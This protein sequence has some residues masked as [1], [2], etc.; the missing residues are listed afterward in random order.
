[1]IQKNQPAM[2]NSDK[3]SEKPLSDPI[4]TFAVIT[5]GHVNPEDDKSASPWESNR[6]A[7][8][9]NR[10][11]VHKL[12]QLAPDFVI[13]LG[14]LI[15]P[16]PSQPS[17]PVAAKRFYEIYQPLES[18]I[19]FVPGNHDVGDKPS[20]WTP[21]EVVNRNFLS[22]FDRH[23]EKDF[24]SFEYHDSLFVLLNSQ[25]FNSGLKEEA[26]QQRWV[27][28]QLAQNSNRRIFIFTHYPPFIT[29]HKEQEHYDNLNEPARS[30]FLNLLDQYSVTALFSGHVHSFFY[31]RFKSTDCYVLPSITF[32]RHDYSELFR[33][34]AAEEHGRNDLGK[35]GFFLVKV[36][37]DSYTAHC[38]RTW[39][40]SLEADKIQQTATRETTGLHTK[41]I[42]WSG[43]GI[44][45]RH[46]WAEITDFP[47]SG[48]VDEFLRKK[49]RNDYPI[50]ALWEMGARRLRVPL[51]DLEDEKTRKRMA[52]LKEMGHL[53]CLFIYDLPSHDSIK[54]IEQHK[55]LLESI[56]VIIPWASALQ[57]IEDLIKMKKKLKLPIYLSKLRSSADAEK[58]GGRFKHFIKHG[59]N[60]REQNLV[61]EFS[62]RAGALKS[63]DGFVFHIGRSD[64]PFIDI[65]EAVDILNLMGMRAQFHVALANENPAIA[66]NNDMA[67][68]NRVAEALFIALALPQTQVVLDTFVDMDR[69]YFPRKGLVDRRYNPRTA[70]HVYRNL[71]NLL[72]P[73]SDKLSIGRSH[74]IAGG[75]ICTLGFSD[76]AWLLALPDK[77]LSLDE[78]DLKALGVS[79][80]ESAA[81]FDLVSGRNY[82]LQLQVVN[83]RHRIRHGTNGSSKLTTPSLLHLF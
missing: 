53:F 39:G 27:E 61:K 65:P 82:I 77:G 15:H 30:W 3:P 50:W 26:R 72:G 8:G 54:F 57:Y 41:E 24:R 76:D 66:E 45:M 44:D 2:S 49:V 43:L 78:L 14:D 13:H 25:L 40:K 69:G 34:M 10:Y 62:K 28:D 9:R 32:F 73:H 1:M 81:L 42:P 70:G 37:P 63:I 22:I 19:H 35:F 36:Y 83:G 23:F 51:Q 48:A 74:Q 67:N 33:V 75:K 7:N 29:H 18:P 46:P 56:E 80:I 58:D 5:D 12:N 6:M 17:Y 4:F 64:E 16:I 59:F 60:L 52:D 21:A 55:R 11:V 79:T 38:I 31:N 20:S 47:Y 68:A 71:N